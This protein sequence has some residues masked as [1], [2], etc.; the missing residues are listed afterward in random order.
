VPEKRKLHR[1]LLAWW[2]A[3]ENQAPCRN[4]VLPMK[5]TIMPTSPTKNDRRPNKAPIPPLSSIRSYGRLGNEKACQLRAA[6]ASGTTQKNA[7]RQPMSPP[8]GTDSAG[9]SR[10]VIAANHEDGVTRRER[11][12]P[13]RFSS[14]GSAG[15]RSKATSSL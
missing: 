6:G 2:N 13:E 5:N 3:L 12:V 8:T 1:E 11:H 10:I 15:S 4:G 7:P 14:N 9:M